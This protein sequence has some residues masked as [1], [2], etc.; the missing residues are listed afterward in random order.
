MLYLNNL[1]LGYYAVRSGSM[2]FNVVEPKGTK[3]TSRLPSYGNG[4]DHEHLTVEFTTERLGDVL[5]GLKTLLTNGEQVYYLYDTDNH[6]YFNSH[7][8][9]VNIKSISY[10]EEEQH[11]E[12]SMNNGA[13]TLNCTVALDGTGSNFVPPSF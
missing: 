3:A 11:H 6:V 7:G 8:C 12:V 2:N 9:W 1:L 4:V 13:V 10:S 5:A